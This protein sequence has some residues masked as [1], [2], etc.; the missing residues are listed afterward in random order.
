M[1]KHQDS[2]GRLENRA[3][4][5]VRRYREKVPATEN[6]YLWEGEK[7]GKNCGHEMKSS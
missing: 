3:C 7:T 6:S 2:G 5:G 4:Y 1:R